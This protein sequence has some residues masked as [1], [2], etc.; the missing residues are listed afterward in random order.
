MWGGVAWFAT[1]SRQLRIHVPILHI[2]LHS[3]PPPSLALPVSS[4][5][6]P[7]RWA[8][9]D[10]MGERWWTQWV[11]LGEPRRAGESMEGHKRY[12]LEAWVYK[13]L[14]VV[15]GCPLDGCPL[16]VLLPMCVG[17]SNGS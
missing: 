9:V 6:G 2:T 13:F 7:C 16:E 10:P 11:N 5:G 4:L 14:V 8:L 12:I 1:E 17:K 15:R 3:A